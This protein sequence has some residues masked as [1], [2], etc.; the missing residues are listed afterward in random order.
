[1]AGF[2]GK[3]IVPYRHGG[4]IYQSQTDGSGRSRFLELM[5]CLREFC[6]VY[7]VGSDDGEPSGTTLVPPA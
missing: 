4:R 2:N 3:R 5:M 1:M 7:S 6:T